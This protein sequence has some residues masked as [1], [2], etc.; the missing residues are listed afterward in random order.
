MNSLRLS[1]GSAATTAPLVMKRTFTRAA[2]GLGSF[3]R[4]RLLAGK[5]AFVQMSR[6]VIRRCLGDGFM[7]SRVVNSLA[8]ARGF[9]LQC[10]SPRREAGRGGSRRHELEEIASAREAAHKRGGC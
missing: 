10:A 6:D 7:A 9:P 8:S 2:Y 1:G 5:Y 4:L 3:S